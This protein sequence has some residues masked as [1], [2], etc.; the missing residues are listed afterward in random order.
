MVSVVPREDSYR[1]FI[2]TQ[3]MLT[4]RE[5]VLSALDELEALV[6]NTMELNRSVTPTVV[7]PMVRQTIDLG[8]GCFKHTLVPSTGVNNV[9]KDS[10]D[11]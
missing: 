9:E 8:N 1:F 7:Q 2:N 4:A 5:A 3:G 6:R 11:T 10:K